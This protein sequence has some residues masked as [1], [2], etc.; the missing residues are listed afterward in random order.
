MSCANIIHHNTMI[1]YKIPVFWKVTN[2]IS[3]AQTTY[4]NKVNDFVSKAQS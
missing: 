2:H 3:K 4:K 1:E